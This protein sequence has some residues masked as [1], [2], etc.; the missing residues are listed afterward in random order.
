VRSGERRNA[1]AH[2]VGLFHSICKMVSLAFED[3]LEQLK[4]DMKGHSTYRLSP[5]LLA[6]FVPVS[7]ESGVTRLLASR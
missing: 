2:S 5:R 3:L 1:D 7:S 6:S 4:G